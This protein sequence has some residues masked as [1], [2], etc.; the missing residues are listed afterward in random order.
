MRAANSVIRYRYNF[1]C[2]GS[3]HEL[4]LYESYNSESGLGSLEFCAKA[5]KIK[6]LL[7]QFELNEQEINATLSL[8]DKRSDGVIINRSG[9]YLSDD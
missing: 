8:A 6:K 2:G 5:I 1:A 4:R 9:E 3:S 7:I